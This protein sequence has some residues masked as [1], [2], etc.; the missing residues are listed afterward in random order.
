VGVNYFLT[1]ATVIRQAMT[2]EAALSAVE[3]SRRANELTELG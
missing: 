3:E 2:A 1:V